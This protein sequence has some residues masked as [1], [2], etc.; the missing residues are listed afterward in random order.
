MD[1][2][3]VGMDSYRDLEVCFFFLVCRAS[4]NIGLKSIDGF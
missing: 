3:V 1:G 4:E 2:V